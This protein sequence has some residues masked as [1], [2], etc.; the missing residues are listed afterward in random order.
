MLANKR[1]KDRIFRGGTTLN[2]SDKG[3]SKKVFYF[4]NIK[5]INKIAFLVVFLMIGIGVINLM[6]VSFMHSIKQLIY[7]IAFLPLFF[8]IV[9]LNP[10][11]FIK[12]APFGFFASIL[13]LLSIF[14]VGDVFMGA[15]RWIDLKIIRFQPSEISKIITVLMI[16]RYYHFLKENEAENLKS[17]FV[18]LGMIFFQIALILKQ[19]DLGTSLTLALIGF[20]V[21]FLA[22]LHLRYFF[23]A[24][25]IALFMIPFIWS[26]LHDYQKQRVKTF[27]NPSEDELGAGYNITQAKIAIGSGGLVGKGIFEGTQGS[28]DFLPESHTD[29]AFTIFAEQFGFLGSISLILLYSYILYFGFSVS[30]KSESHFIRLASGGLTCLIFFHI[31]INL[32]MTSG[33]IPVV[34]NPLPLISYGG[35]FLFSTLSCLAMLLNFDINQSIIIHSSKE[36]YME[37]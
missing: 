22:G 7:F 16:A 34:G 23:I 35:T 31:I 29:F 14:V 19:P 20:S 17:A 15:R 32:A 28:L 21:I 30:V 13:L 5:N 24:F 33:L 36:S 4:H 6:A 37:K 9:S 25:L 8:C 1:A 3:F 26:N 10:R 12:L 18:P 11:Y 2:K 27:L